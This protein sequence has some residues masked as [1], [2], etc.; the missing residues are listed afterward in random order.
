[1]YCTYNIILIFSADDDYDDDDCR[2]LSDSDDDV[3]DHHDEADLGDYCN[4]RYEKSFE[5][6]QRCKLIACT[7]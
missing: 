1:M 2:L 6:N 5:G 4:V 3:D 7:G